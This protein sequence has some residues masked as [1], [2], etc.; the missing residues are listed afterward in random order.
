MNIRAR[1]L[2]HQVRAGNSKASTTQPVDEVE[3]NFASVKDCVRNIF[4]DEAGDLPLGEGPLNE[5]ARCLMSTPYNWRKIENRNPGEAVALQKI[6]DSAGGFLK[7]IEFFKS[8]QAIDQDANGFVFTSALE[9]V[10]NPVRVVEHYARELTKTSEERRPSAW[11]GYAANFYYLSLH[12]W[13]QGGTS[14][15]KGRRRRFGI[16]RN[17]P[18]TKV[19]KRILDIT[20][21]NISLYSISEFLEVCDDPPPWKPD[22]LTGWS[23]L[24]ARIHHSAF[25]MPENKGSRILRN[26]CTDENDK[27]KITN[28]K[29]NRPRGRPRKDKRSSR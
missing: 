11:K 8:S 5:L 27:E 6:V 16:H 24:M 3:R 17:G 2:G 12:V 7:A 29:T 21:K 28:K 15:W 25:E 4:K 1:R 10:L 13:E 26:L 14:L 19:V 22:S 18:A 20:G 9:A 23:I